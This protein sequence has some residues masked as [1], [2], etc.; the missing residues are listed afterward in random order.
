MNHISRYDLSGFPAHL[1]VIHVQQHDI[2]ASN[3]KVIDFVVK[4]DV[5][6]SYLEQEVDRLYQLLED[7]NFDA[8]SSDESSQDQVNEKVSIFEERLADMD[9]RRAE[10]RA[11][12]ILTG[13]QFTKEMQ[14][15]NIGVLSG[16]WRQR[17]A[18]ACAL[19][20]TPDLLLLDEPTNHLD[21]PAVKW[22]AEFL[23]NITF[24]LVVVS[25]DRSFLNQIC[26]DVMELHNKK[27]DYY[28]GNYDVF[29]QVKGDLIKQRKHDYEVQQK[30]L[31]E[32][33]QY[34]EEAKKSDNQATM[35]SGKA[36]QILLAKMERDELIE[37]VVE[38]KQFKFTFPVPT[39]LDHAMLEINDMSFGYH[40]H[41]M[42]MEHVSL[43]MDLDSRIGLL[44]TNGQ[45]R[46]KSECEQLA[47]EP[48]SN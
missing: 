36:R 39:K 15:S 42:L 31:T 6:K 20:S 29:V 41:K 17:V 28:K 26:T 40:E 21:F 16:G 47:S 3:D 24:T 48:R 45:L 22:L 44:G 35:Q 5:E 25:H 46:R 18:L 13:L 4:S 2:A 43:H 33:R 27:L 32:M 12:A 23:K 30:K 10:Q 8:N 14:Q 11:A 19:Q 37:P 9:A 38:D 1:R 34:I 7:G